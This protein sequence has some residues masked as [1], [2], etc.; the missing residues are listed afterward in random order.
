MPNHFEVVLSLRPGW[1]SRE[2]VAREAIVLAGRLNCPVAFLLPGMGPL[3]LCE[4]TI[5][6]TTSS[7]V[8]DVLEQMAP[9][10]R[11]ATPGG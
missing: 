9:P 10:V 7:T 6:V 4:G 2:E 11:D 1:T 8:A 5:R 3:G